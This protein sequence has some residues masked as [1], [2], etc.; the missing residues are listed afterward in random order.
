MGCLFSFRWSK[1]KLGKNNSK[2][3]TQKKTH[4][5]GPPILNIF[6][7]KFHGLVIGLVGF[8]DVIATQWNQAARS[9]E[10]SFISAL[11]MVSSESWKSLYPNQYAQ[12]S[13]WNGIGEKSEFER[14]VATAI[15]TRRG[16]WYSSFDWS[17]LLI[18][19]S[20]IKNSK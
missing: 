14:S 13:K 2:W 16:K 3:L 10:V 9:Y 8:I 20:S 15:K 12:N 6:L 4:F 1:K 17:P 19:A 11:W 5:L 7:R 18:Y